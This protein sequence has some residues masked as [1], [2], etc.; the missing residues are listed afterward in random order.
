MGRHSSTLTADSGTSSAVR[1]ATLTRHRV[2]LTLKDNLDANIVEHEATDSSERTFV[3]AVDLDRTFV[4]Q[5]RVKFNALVRSETPLDGITSQVMAAVKAT[6]A[7]VDYAL[8]Y[9]YRHGMI[10]FEG[11]SELVSA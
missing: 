7:E 11:F 1:S 9:L 8:D 10:S 4:R 6:E 3:T 5:V 2:T